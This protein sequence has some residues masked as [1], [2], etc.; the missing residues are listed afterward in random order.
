MQGAFPFYQDFYRDRAW[1]PK[2]PER[3]FYAWLSDREAASRADAVRQW[4]CREQCLTGTPIGLHRLHVSVHPIGDFG[5]LPNSIIYGAQ[6]AGNAVSMPPFDVTFRSV[7]SFE[8]QS[9]WNGMPDRWP[10]VLLGDSGG[11]RTLHHK[12]GAA[13]AKHGLRPGVDFKPHMTLLYGTRPVPEQKIEPIRFVVHDFVLIHSER[14]LTRYNVK[15]R[16]PLRG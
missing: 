8:R 14:G 6:L 11:L 7:K 13:M 5:R 4:V 10:V 16:W 9:S 15:D 2:R 12:L 1:R 3:L